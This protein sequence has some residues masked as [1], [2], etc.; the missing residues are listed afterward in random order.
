MVTAAASLIGQTISHY[1]IVAKLGGGG[2]GAVYDA[3]DTRLGRHVALKFVPEE[4]VHDRK[5][6]ERFFWEARA[7]SQL[8]HPGICTIHDIEDIDGHPF[9]V[10][11]KLEGVSLKDR[12]LNGKPVEL[13]EILDIGIQVSDALA[14][15]HAKGI[16]HR[17]IKPANIFITNNGQVK[18]LDFGVAK[19]SPGMRA[20]E[21]SLDDPLTVAGDIFG[22]AVYMSPEQARGEE[23][24]PRTD[25]FSFGVVLYQ[26]AT[27]QRPFAGTNAVT[28]LEAVMNRKPTSPLKLNPN[29]PPELEGIIGR[30]MEKERGNRY[31]N[32]SALKGDLQSL[33]RDTESG[34]TATGRL[35]PA[36]PYRIATTTF[37]K[38]SRRQTYI[39][40]G[41]IA[42]LV[43]LLV[44]M[45]AWFFK[46]RAGAHAKNSI[47]V[48]PLQ[49]VNGDVSVDFLRFALA[50]EI[51]NALT[52]TRTLD[53]RP[54][55]LTRRYA[56]SDVDP[57]KAAAE[58]RASTIVTGHF[59]KQGDSLMV[60][61]EAVD[62]ANDKLLWQTNLTAPADDLT[63]LQSTL[64]AQ[65]NQGLLPAIGIT[66]GQLAAET[67][68]RPHDPAAYDLYLHSLAL[69]HDPAPNKDAIAVLEHA[70]AADPNYAPAWEELGMRYYYDYSYSDGGEQAF[71]LS[72]QAYQRALALDPNRIVAAGQLITNRVER[73]ELGKA[74]Q[75]AQALLRRRPESAE[76]HF[77][78]GYVYRYAGMLPEA[79][80][81]CNKALALDPGNYTFRS[82]A[83]AFLDMGD[84]KRAADFINLDAASEWAAYVKPSLLLREGEIEQARDAV[85]KMPTAPRYHRDLLEA[86]L[87][88]APPEEADRMAH[89]TEVSPPAA[90]DSELLYYQ[91]ALFA[92]CG[93]RQAA[94]RMLQAAIEQNYCAYSNLQL[95]PMLRKIRTTP[96]FDKLLEAARECQ[97]A[98]LTASGETT[99]P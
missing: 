57:R 27:G 45:G 88:L 58:L 64:T 98:V 90:P 32:A 15:C 25:L 44:P 31:P 30:A 10:M 71:Q 51:A 77:V 59:L 85:T 23:L 75:A 79:E 76:A 13:E 21:T 94:L 6:L 11:E 99:G 81:Q 2:M 86:C 18:L 39:L 40:L 69:P 33:K 37:Q 36:L 20:G 46:L 41:V 60:T 80:Q 78:M 38:D 17:D 95:D 84:T 8:N 5:A 29:L 61:L 1:R 54:S 63:K 67:G 12:M 73:G 7:A 28:T 42:L 43:T 91:G 82:C 53:V 83:W 56:G 35:R 62:G 89:E 92:D 34:L 48:L 52:T 4:L 93:K 24:D 9:I 97:D 55:S 47:A 65:V 87:G 14:A 22:T 70:V 19:L 16:I 72:T 96:G 3:E 68:N 26:M 50:D 66:G 74:Y 49:N